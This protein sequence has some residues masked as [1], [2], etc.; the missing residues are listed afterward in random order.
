MNTSTCTCITIQKTHL[1]IRSSPASEAHPATWRCN[2]R[3]C[4][5]VPAATWTTYF[6]HAPPLRTLATG[7]PGAGG[8]PC[9]P[10]AG[11]S[12]HSRHLLPARCRPR[13]CSRGCHP[14]RFCRWP[15][16]LRHQTIDGFVFAVFVQPTAVVAASSGFVIVVE[17]KHSCQLEA[18]AL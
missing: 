4:S 13:C 3:L 14:N 9:W 17:S 6:S 5:S 1:F 16:G 11:S 15:P 7:R 2:H 18:S 8:L 10:T 12:A